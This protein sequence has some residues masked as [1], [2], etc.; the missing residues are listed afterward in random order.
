MRFASFH[1]DGQD[2][3]GVALT[4]SKI[5]DLPASAWPDVP[6]DLLSFIQ[7]GESGRKLAADMLDNHANA[8][9]VNV[10]DI[11]WHPPIPRPGKIC[12]IA[13]NNSAPATSARSARRIT[14]RF[15]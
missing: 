11:D 3:Y 15:S 1:A 12:G 2:T 7:A 6:R 13:M 10:G 5:I 9:T 14:L 4:D 8:V